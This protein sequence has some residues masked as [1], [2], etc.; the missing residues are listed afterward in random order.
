M[1]DDKMECQWSRLSGAAKGLGVFDDLDDRAGIALTRQ[2]C[3]LCWSMCRALFLALSVTH[4]TSSSIS[5]IG[6]M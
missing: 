5:A 6:E 1:R 4:A 3:T 2:R